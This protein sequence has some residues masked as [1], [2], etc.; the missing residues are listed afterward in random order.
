MYQYLGDRAPNAKNKGTFFSSTLKVREKKVALVS[1][2]D[3][4]LHNYWQFI[5]SLTPR[6]TRRL[7][8]YEKLAIRPFKKYLTKWLSAFSHP[9]GYNEWSPKKLGHFDH[10]FHWF[11]APLASPPG[12]PYT[13]LLVNW[14][15]ANIS[16]TKPLMQKRKVDYYLQHWKWLQ[17]FDFM[18]CCTAIGTLRIC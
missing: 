18:F 5:N 13:L 3:A 1:W 16:A 9:N 17:F 8:R 11:S 10:S 6:I 15:C 4:L 14:Q 12:T 7:W 2:F